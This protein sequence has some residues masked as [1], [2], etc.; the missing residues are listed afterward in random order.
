MP[1][2]RDRAGKMGGCGDGTVSV[3]NGM[4]LIQTYVWN[5]V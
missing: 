1:G 3:L 2:V 4:V 5:R